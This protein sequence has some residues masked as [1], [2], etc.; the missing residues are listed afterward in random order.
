M[1]NCDDCRRDFSLC[2]K[3]T[4][5]GKKRRKLES[6]NRVFFSNN[7]SST[8]R[9]SKYVKCRYCSEF[10]VKRVS[11]NHDCFLCK[12]D[13]IFGN[14]KKRS[15]TI[16]AQNIFYYDI[17]SRLENQLECRF[18]EITMNGDVITVRKSI[19]VIDLKSVNSLKTTLTNREL[20]CMEVVKRKSHL[21][22]F[23][24]VINSSQSL[25]KHFC[26]TMYDDVITSFFS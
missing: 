13:S 9:A 2:L 15:T 14:E 21:P 18:Q 12:T 16:H 17:E 25:K 26:E 6:S 4:H 7:S 23:L 19:M 1:R 22:T 5:F 10:Y 20:N 24:C 11:N 3:C 8:F